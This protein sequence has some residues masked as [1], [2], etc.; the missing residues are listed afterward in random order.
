MT[1][2][3]GV[4]ERSFSRGMMYYDESMSISRDRLRGIP[5]DEARD[6]EAVRIAGNAPSKGNNDG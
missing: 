4:F 6:I 1:Y 3:G 2:W 5:V